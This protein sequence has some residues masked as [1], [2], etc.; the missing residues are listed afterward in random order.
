[1]KRC[2]YNLML[3]IL[4][5]VSFCF[6]EIIFQCRDFGSVEVSVGQEPVIT[7][8]FYQLHMSDTASIEVS[9]SEQEISMSFDK[10]SC[11]IEYVQLS[12]FLLFFIAILCKFTRLQSKRYGNGADFGHGSHLR[13]VCYI[14]EADGKK[15][16]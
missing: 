8:S 1:M 3:L 9:G 7:G 11:E 13:V 15:R 16:A 2:C 6:S 5:I 14:Q 12:A 10:E 4:L